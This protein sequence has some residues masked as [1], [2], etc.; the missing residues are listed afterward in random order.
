MTD[1]RLDV[2][3]YRPYGGYFGYYP[4]PEPEKAGND[5]SNTA[6][7]L[8]ATAD[9]TIAAQRDEIGVLDEALGES[10]SL[11]RELRK[12]IDAQGEQIQALQE[13][14]DGL[15][16]RQTRE[17]ELERSLAGAPNGAPRGERRAS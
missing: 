12:Q 11:I 4:A 8:L 5:S 6:R 9:A 10:W 7:T 3:E 17:Y 16:E 1:E 14:A 15:V 2:P 13:Y